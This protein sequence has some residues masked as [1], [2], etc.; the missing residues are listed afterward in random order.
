M[1]QKHTPTPWE[2]GRNTH[3]IPGIWT[4]RGK[5]VVLFGGQNGEDDHG[6][7]KYEK[8]DKGEANAAHIVKCVNAHDQLVAALRTQRDTC[9]FVAESM[10]AKH[11]KLAMACREAMLSAQE[12][13]KAAGEEV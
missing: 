2:V 12:A 1:K 7:P 13:L 3:E 10:P 11:R 8:T 6:M 4:K 5:V 9:G